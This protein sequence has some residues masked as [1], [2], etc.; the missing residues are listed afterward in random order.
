FIAYFNGFGLEN[1]TTYGLDYMDK[2]SSATY[3][4]SKY[5]EE[6][7]DSLALFVENQLWITK[8]WSVTGGL[9]WDDYTRDAV[10]DSRE[11]DDVTW[12]LA[13]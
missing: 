4:G 1:A 11:F 10:N 3:G 2:R 13:T 12:A 8:D 9:R 5:M 7:A 6:S